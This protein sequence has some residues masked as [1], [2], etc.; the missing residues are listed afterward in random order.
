MKNGFVIGDVGC[1]L[2]EVCNSIVSHSSGI[3]VLERNTNFNPEERIELERAKEMYHELL[4]DELEHAQMLVLTL[5]RLIAPEDEHRSE[6]TDGDGG[7]FAAGELEDVKDGE[8]KI[9]EEE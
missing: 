2:R 1:Q 9:E 5:T 6:N 3:D 4:M 8:V 7:V